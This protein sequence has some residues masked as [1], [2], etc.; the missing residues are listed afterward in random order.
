MSECI[1]KWINDN[2]VDMYFVKKRKSVF[3][4]L[5]NILLLSGCTGSQCNFK[6]V[7]MPCKYRKQVDSV[8]GLMTLE[9]KIG[10]MNQYSGNYQVTGPK[11]EDTT[12][13]RQ[14]EEGLVGSV[15]NIK[16]V[17]QTRDLQAC[18]MKSRL[19]IPLIFGLD[20]IHGMRTVF[21]LPLAEAASFDL[22][23]MRRT[24]AGAAWEASS[25]GIHWTF[26]PMM[27][28]SR[29]PRWGRV[30][31][32]AGEDTWYGTL[33]A[34]ARVKGFQ[35]DDLSAV[36]TVMACA[37]HFAAYGACIAGKDYNTTDMSLL[38]LHETYLPPF[39]A[40]VEEGVA[41]VMNSFNDLNGV[42]ATGNTYL[43]RDLLKGKWS[44]D[45]VTVSDWG[46]VGE[47]VAHGYS[48]DLRQ[49]AEQAV[50]AGCDVDMES[51]AY[52]SHLKELVESGAVSEKYIDDA[53]RRILLKKFELGL[54]DDPFRYCD[55]EREKNTVLCDSLKS[56]ARE[57]G[58]K[59]VVLLK[60]D[61]NVLPLARS[62]VK[63]A[64]IGALA[65][66]Q[67]DMMGLWSNEGVEEEVVT[68]LEGLQRRFGKQNVRYAEGYDIETNALKLGDA[69]RV[70]DLSDVI[71]VAVGERSNNS[72]EARSRAD[73]NI[74]AEHQELVRH[75]KGTGKKVIVLLMGGR[76]MIFNEMEPYSDA[77]L[78]TWWLG[79]EAG[80]SIADVLSGD[81]NPSGKLPMTFPAHIG[82]IPIYYN[83]K[84][85]GR[86]E[87][88]SGG[89]TCGY[90]D[91]DFEPA[92]PFGYGLSYT[93]FSIGEPVISKTK[94][95]KGEP[96]E[97]RVTVENVGRYAGKETVQLYV[98]DVT[99]S[100]TRPVKELRGFSQVYLNPGEKKELTFILTEAELGFYNRNLEYIVEP[101]KFVVMA[102]PDSKN[103]KSAKFEIL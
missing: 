54:F 55:F 20:V 79:T 85:T 8:L 89:Y 22:D 45:G 14:I 64:L 31:E 58:K 37:K 2:I 94:W 95:E 18:A 68:V 88:K 86:P 97:V 78:L 44:F 56:L 25:Q 47:M 75:L 1:K 70:A 39:K 13:L 100:V 23:L 41:S 32:G 27:D 57:A 73:I 11:I 67:V 82:Q 19:K 46:S 52:V 38:T 76:P 15:L 81:Y 102:G 99:G 30:M 34:K 42:P 101:G 62:G 84:S 90:Q 50:T 10:Q 66:S 91:I 29:D 16:G 96:V 9:E 26:A 51:R 33:V 74:P 77:I 63:I 92:Y 7:D 49:A 43:Q 59:S 61:G 12:K 65:D 5:A 103:L 71:V 40:V 72:G 80:N 98:R 48:A 24:A 21:P 53:V 28:V 93:E 69:F 87:S 4:A 35:G 36:N 60:N 83:Y 6:E 3:I 17:Q